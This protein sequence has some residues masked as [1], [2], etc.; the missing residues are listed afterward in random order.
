MPKKIDRKKIKEILPR[1]IDILGGRE[2]MIVRMYYGLDGEEKMS[3]REIGKKLGVS[4]ERVRQ[5]EYRAI[6]KI[7]KAYQEVKEMLKG[8]TQETIGEPIKEEKAGAPSSTHIKDLSID[9]GRSL[10]ILSF[11]DG[12]SL[13]F[14]ADKKLLDRISIRKPSGN[15]WIGGHTM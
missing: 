5:I 1:Y 6:E 2:K 9:R 8:P 11:S 13:T 7:W 3:Y 10:I 4:G 14:T 12:G 15:Q